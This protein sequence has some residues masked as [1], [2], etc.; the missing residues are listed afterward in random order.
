MKSNFPKGQFCFPIKDY[1]YNGNEQITFGDK[2]YKIKFQRNKNEKDKDKKKK[3]PKFRDL[4]GKNP[5][6]IKNDCLIGSTK[7]STCC[8]YNM[9]GMIGCIYLGSIYEGKTNIGR[10]EV[11]CGNVDE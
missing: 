11:E 3:K 10:F 7:E 6:K 8:Y 4:C 9:L 2:T 5:A 1:L